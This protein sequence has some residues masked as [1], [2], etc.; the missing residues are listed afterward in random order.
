MRIAIA[1]ALGLILLVLVASWFAPERTII[2]ERLTAPVGVTTDALRAQ[3][4]DLVSWRRWSPI[5]TSVEHELETT[6]GETTSG[7]GGRMTLVF[8]GRFGVLLT[9]AKSEPNLLV[10]EARSGPIEEDLEG[11]AGFRSWD[12]IAFEE[13]EDGLV[14][15]V[16]K[17]TGADLELR[18]LRLWDRLV[19]AP[20]AREQ[21]QGGL[22]ALVAAAGGA[23]LQ[24]LEAKD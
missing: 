16:W 14:T 9:I 21:I 10:V 20:R 12:E 7:V 17:R 4:H 18:I 3:T 5:F 22:A 2:E 11:G 8:D 1:T 15:V 23:S 24:E 6:G 19:V 13:G